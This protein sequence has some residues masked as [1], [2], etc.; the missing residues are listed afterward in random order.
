MLSAILLQP[1][2]LRAPLA[3]DDSVAFQTSQK[4][5]ST[6]DELVRQRASLGPAQPVISYPHTGIEYVDYPLRQL[7]VYAFRVAE[8]LA[9]RIPPRTSSAETPAVMSLLGPSD[10]NYLVMLLSLAK[11]GHSGLLLSTRIS[12]DAYVSLLERTQSRHIFIHPSFRETAEEVKK[13]VPDLLI[14]EIPTEDCYDFPVPDDEIDTNLTPSLDPATEAKHIAWIIHSSGSTGLPKPIFHTQQAALKNYAG[15]MNM[16][17]FVTLPLYHNHGIS[18]LFRTIHARKQLHLYNAR[19]PLTRQHLLDIM[20][21]HNFEIFYGV[22]YGL[23]LLAETP[24]GIAA[25]GKFK[26]VMFGGSACP[27][28]LG[29]LLVEN[30]VHLIS[31]YGSTETGQLMMSTRPRDDKGWD[32]LRP[33]EFVQKYLQFEERFPG[34]FELICLDGWPSKVMSNRPDGSYA[35]KDLFVKHP[36]ITAYKYYARL[37]DTLVLVNGEKV[38]PLDLEGRVRQSCAVSEAIVFGA[39][40]ACIGLAVIRAPDSQALTDDEIVEAIWPAVERAHESMPAFGQLSKNMVRVL[41]ADAQ[42]PR[43]DKGTVIR[44]GFYR[45]YERLIEEAYEADDATTGALVLSEE[46]LRSFL[47]EQL[48]EILPPK[49]RGDLTDDAD[50]F[51]LGMDSLQATQLRSVI[52]RKIDT[53]GH[54]LGLN[55]AFEQPTVRSLAHYLNGLKTGARDSGESIV[56]QMQ[57]MIDKYSQFEEHVPCANDL[58]GQYILITGSTGSLGSHVVAQLAAN[59]NV[60]K[61]Y[62]P[63]RAASPIDAYTRLH[64]SLQARRI[65]TCMTPEARN[66]LVALPSDL[67]DPCLGLAPAVYTA[68]TTELTT[69]IHCAWSVNFNLTLSSL[70]K[71]NIGG[72]RNLLSLCLRVQRPQPATFNFCSSVSAVVNS[73]LNPVPE[74]LPTSLSAAQ[75]MGYAQSKLVAEHICACAAAQTP[76]FGVRILRIG[77][78]IGDTVHGIWNTTE[79]IPLILQSARTIGALP[80]LDEDPLWLPVD[81]VA[82]AVIDISSTLPATTPPP[83]AASSTTPTPSP[84]PSPFPTESA[85]TNTSVYNIVNPQSFHWTRD[86]L[87]ALR[88]AGLDGFEELPPKEWVRRLRAH[89]DPVRNPPAKLVDFF[90]GKYDVDEAVLARRRR[91]AF[92]TEKARRVSRG[93]EAAGTVV[94]GG[95]ASVERMVGWFLG[96]GWVG[97]LGCL[98]G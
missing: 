23:K 31:H 73:D 80:A 66:K 11:L 85:D 86:L 17:G 37:D 64:Q 21:S 93:L 4:E 33:S 98:P 40:K 13:R 70:E 67:S 20:N 29:N 91:L 63:V 59:A 51:A 78:V 15:H 96:G 55:I 42:Y 76:G 53:N 43:T 26:A 71:D 2:T 36:T 10:L 50:F 27:D 6:I 1:P 65:Y 9:K 14:D 5:P 79:A 82:R 61:I 24:E 74:A 95:G 7:D 81:V 41:P 44:Q 57:A 19:L 30:G 60:K 89:P 38:N 18:C 87:P 52:S 75:G 12:V 83:A 94:D 58:D 32:W 45:E 46:E 16:S 34:V 84:S 68:L 56:E 77:Q 22:P 49:S 88:R 72:L 3:K 47:R 92:R 69:V 97:A 54:K 62:C 90:A 35:T 48:S 8:V 25:L 39:G 28:S